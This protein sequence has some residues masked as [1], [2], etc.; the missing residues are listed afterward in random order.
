MHKTSFQSTRGIEEPSLN[1]FFFLTLF[2]ATLR[3]NGGWVFIV[4]A[5]VL[6]K[7]DFV[8]YII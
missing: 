4:M 6:F 1:D 5:L 8:T 2:E 3:E 7:K